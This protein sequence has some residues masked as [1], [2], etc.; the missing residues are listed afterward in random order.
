M[1]IRFPKALAAVFLFLFI[2]GMSSSL[3]AQFTGTLEINR[4]RIHETGEHSLKDNFN[5]SLNPDRILLSSG[6]DTAIDMMGAF[7]ANRLI[8]RHDY[9]D[10]VFLGSRSEA[11][12]LK[13]DELLS[14]VNLMKNVRGLSQDPA[15]QGADTEM[16]FEETSETDAI[17]GYQAQKWLMHSEN[18]QEVFHVWLTDGLQ[19]N[20]GV[21]S[22]DWLTDL[23]LFSDLPFAEWMGTGRTPVKV[24]RYENERLTDRIVL[25][26]I[27]ERQLPSGYFEIPEE[28]E[29]INF[30]QLLI[31]RMS[32][33]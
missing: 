25:E 6:N 24:E 10:F 31:R 28:A 22:E 3:Q 19:V 15:E 2:A 26:N 5:L 30:Q 4:Y 20:W 32:G 33:R 29:V 11:I 17:N 16:Q 23:T 9:E 18:K 12:L 21:L 7:N 27:R 8:I 14:M 13:K 1:K